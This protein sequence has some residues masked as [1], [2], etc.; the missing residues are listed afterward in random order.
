MLLRI[1][2]K[3]SRYLCCP[4][5]SMCKF[6]VDVPKLSMYC[7]PSGRRSWFTASVSLLLNF[8]K[9][10]GYSKVANT[11]YLNL[12]ECFPM[13]YG[14]C[15]CCFGSGAYQHCSHE[16]LLYSNPPMEFRH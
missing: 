1:H 7:W 8:L 5:L 11:Q 10:I 14:P 2:H 15:C 13:F 16:G 12:L 3:V 4:Q 6:G 9:Q